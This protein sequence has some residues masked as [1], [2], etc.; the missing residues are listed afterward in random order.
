MTVFRDERG[1]L[2]HMPY[3]KARSHQERIP[4]ISHHPLDVKRGTFIGEMSRL[5]TL[6][7]TH[8]AY[9]TAIKGLVALYIARG[10]PPQFVN[11]WF[12]SNFTERWNKRLNV[13]ERTPAEVLVLKT[14]Y[15]TAWNYFN[16]TE[17]GNTIF[18]Y[19]RTWLDRA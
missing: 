9:A 15:N 17:F 12:K 7:S 19:W 14:E 8:E 16:A 5:A 6:C 3:R 10:Y 1:L 4:W 18:G 11:S 2:Q 13:H